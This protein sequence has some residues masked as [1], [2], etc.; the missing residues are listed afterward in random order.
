MITL[1][2]CLHATYNSGGMERIIINKANY[3]AERGYKV[4]IITTEQ[5]GRTSFFKLHP[6]IKLI[7]LAINYSL[8]N[9]SIWRKALFY[10]VK[11]YKHKRKLSSILK[12]IR[13]DIV[14]ST[15]G[16]EVTFLHKIKINGKKILEI[17]FSKNF[18]LQLNRAGLWRL[19]DIFRTK[20]DEKLVRKYDSFVVLT[21]EDKLL[22]GNIPNIVVIPNFI[23]NTPEQKTN[24]INHKVL[25][26]GRLSYQKGFDRLIEIW[27]VIHPKFK[28]WSLNIYGSGEEKKYLMA[29]I[30]DKGLTNAV[31]I[32]DPIPDLSKVYS[33]SSIFVLTS[34]YEGFPMVLLE[35]MSHGLPIVSYKCKC[36]PTDLITNDVDGILIEEDDQVTFIQELTM[37][38]E[39]V[40]KRKRISDQSLIKIEKFSRAKIMNQW[41][42]LITQML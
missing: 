24:L 15:F 7:D 18:R 35:A 28:D 42:K 36:G 2:Y 27:E 23:M 30:R 34:R 6:D 33:Q 10:H 19:V 25:A 29:L 3:F 5:Q 22:W 11:R 1:V 31:I 12:E 4:Y 20:M 8:D 38:M 14:V 21:Q 41:E 9:D 26:V 40:E 13:A 16:N 17:H 39:S 37:L 32:H